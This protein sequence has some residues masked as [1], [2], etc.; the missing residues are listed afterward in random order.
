MLNVATMLES[1]KGLSLYDYMWSF[2]MSFFGLHNLFV[3]EPVYWSGSHI[4][5]NDDKGF[6]EIGKASIGVDDMASWLKHVFSSVDPTDPSS[7]TDIYL[8]YV[9]SIS[10]NGNLLD[11][12][13]I[14]ISK[15]RLLAELLSEGLVKG[16]ENEIE[17]FMAGLTEDESMD[18]FEA[19]YDNAM[20]KL[21]PPIEEL[22][23]GVNI[24]AFVFGDDCVTIKETERSEFEEFL[25]HEIKYPGSYER[26]VL[27]KKQEHILKNPKCRD[28]EILHRSLLC[29]TEMQMDMVQRQRQR[30]HK[31]R[32]GS[33]VKST[34]VDGV[35]TRTNAA[36][37]AKK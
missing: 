10:E 36:R 11:A 22:L 20:V 30:M 2:N 34:G 3:D 29:L 1:A 37:A 13:C 9:K 17:V 25:L 6:S 21:G 5:I 27:L 4:K 18:L 33:Y 24:D 31:K 32:I 14:R 12:E 15:I 7:G 28:P 26:A 8:P 19:I 23:E 35:N 16:L